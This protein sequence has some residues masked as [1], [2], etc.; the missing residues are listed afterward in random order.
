MAPGTLLAASSD[1][2]GPC[3]QYDERLTCVA[4]GTPL[5]GM[6]SVWCDLMYDMQT[7]YST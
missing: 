6:I 4:R 2:T 1:G 5:V 7:A 3:Y